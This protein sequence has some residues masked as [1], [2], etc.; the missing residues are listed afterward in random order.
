ML[1]RKKGHE[2]AKHG[3]D[4]LGGAVANAHTDPGPWA[5]LC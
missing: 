4:R 3:R 5:A 1:L 2:G